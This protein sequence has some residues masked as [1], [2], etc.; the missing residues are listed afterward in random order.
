M[1]A[2]EEGETEMPNVTKPGKNGYVKGE[3]IYSLDNKPTPECHASTIV[4]TKSGLVAAWFA[5]TEE[6]L[7]A[8]F[9]IGA[10]H[11]QLGEFDEAI[12]YFDNVLNF[13]DEINQALDDFYVARGF[14]AGL[15][16]GIQQVE[17]IANLALLSK[18]FH[19][20]TA[21]GGKNDVISVIAG[22]I[23]IKLSKRVKSKGGESISAENQALK[24]EFLLPCRG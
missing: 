9:Y 16:Y 2:L 12:K 10:T 3:L 13:Q 7:E 15:R 6:A 24:A 17:A 11:N 22:R 14:D 1:S 20:I 18:V 21:G 5:G 23:A 8:K 4:E 19:R